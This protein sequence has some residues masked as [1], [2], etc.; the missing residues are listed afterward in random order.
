ML[1]SWIKCPCCLNPTPR[2]QAGK[3]GAIKCYIE[4]QITV[5]PP[6]LPKEWHNIPFFLSRV[7]TLDDQR[8]RHTLTGHSGKVLA[9]KFMGDNNKVNKLAQAYPSR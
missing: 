2:G 7:W 3:T 4:T 6:P 1:P 9:A 5:P 8:L